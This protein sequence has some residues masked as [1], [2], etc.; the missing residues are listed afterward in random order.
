LYA[1][2]TA[3]SAL[4]IADDE[5]Q[6]LK[7]ASISSSRFCCIDAVESLRASRAHADAHL[8]LRWPQ[9]FSQ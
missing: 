5:D 7:L 6:N 1:E 9:K 2:E 4:M 3:N 8:Q